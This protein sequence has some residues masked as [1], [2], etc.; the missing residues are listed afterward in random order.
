MDQTTKPSSKSVSPQPDA[1]GKYQT[2]PGNNNPISRKLNKILDSRIEN[3]KDLL[4]ALKTLSGFFPENS[5]RSRRNLRSEIEKRSLV[6]NEEF[7]N[8]FRD[9]KE[10]SVGVFN[11]LIKI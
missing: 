2:Q 6:L 5:I 9:I 8:A 11:Q 4:E 10:V 1:V 3:D 7:L